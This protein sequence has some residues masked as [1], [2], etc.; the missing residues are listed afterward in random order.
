MHGACRRAEH[1]G[2][3]TGAC[4]GHTAHKATPL[5]CIQQGKLTQ[6]APPHPLLCPAAEDAA[7]ALVEAAHKQWAVRYRGRNCDD[8][9][10]RFLWNLDLARRVQCRQQ[11]RAGI[12]RMEA[13]DRRRASCCSPLHAPHRTRPSAPAQ[14]GP[15]PP[16]PTTTTTAGDCC[17]CIPGPLKQRPSVASLAR[18]P[19]LPA[20]GATPA[21]QG[22]TLP[23]HHALTPSPQL[24]VRCPVGHAP[25]ATVGCSGGAGKPV[26]RRPLPFLSFDVSSAPLLGQFCA[27]SRRSPRRALPAYLPATVCAGRAWLAGPGLCRSPHQ[28]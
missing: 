21:P 7:H 23:A 11:Q 10:G 5:G 25:S 4:C 24:G 13:L 17:C 9:S 16:P 27:A 19:T 8:V 6:P 22:T 3:R 14:P 18:G 1:Q 2:C 20:Q 15:P 28:T 12:A 26:P